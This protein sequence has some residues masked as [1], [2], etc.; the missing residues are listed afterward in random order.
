M[1]RLTDYI[2]TK[3]FRKIQIGTATLRQRILQKTIRRGI[4]ASTWIETATTNAKPNII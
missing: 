4:F 3:S 1:V 2:R